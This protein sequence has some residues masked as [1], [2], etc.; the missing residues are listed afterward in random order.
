MPPL[1]FTILERLRLSLLNGVLEE[2]IACMVQLLQL[3]ERAASTAFYHKELQTRG[4]I[5]TLSQLFDKW[6]AE[7]DIARLSIQLLAWIARDPDARERFGDQSQ[8]PHSA[9]MPKIEQWMTTHVLVPDVQRFGCEFLFQCGTHVANQRHLKHFLPIVVRALVAHPSAVLVQQ[10][11]CAALQKLAGYPETARRM[12]NHEDGSAVRLILAAMASHRT[13]SELVERAGDTLYNISID[14]E[15]K[16]RLL[17][18]PVMP[19]V[20]ESLRA[21][22]GSFDVAVSMLD[23]VKNLVPPSGAFSSDAS[24]ASTM[25]QFLRSGLLQAI[26]ELLQKSRATFSRYKRSLLQVLKALH[27][28]DASARQCIR[29]AGILELLRSLP[30]NENPEVAALITSLEQS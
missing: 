17:L 8:Q 9:L 18:L 15:A 5:S 1:H 3:T 2:V 11:A 24:P 22:S 25:N 16:P 26:A 28:A 7:A 12:V 6:K 29:E 13:D 21:H 4:V 20:I 14:G 10:R 30:T 23:V 27:A 19:Q